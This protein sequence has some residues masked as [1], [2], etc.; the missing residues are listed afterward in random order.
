MPEGPRDLAT[1]LGAYR[2]ALLTTR[3]ADGHLRCRPMA[4]RQKVRGEEIWFAT[5]LASKKCKDLE[6]DPRCA[7]A[8]F[9]A[10]DGTTLSISGRGEVLRDRNLA[11][12][13]WDPSW[14]RWFPGGPAQRG[15]AL[16]R[17]IPDH[18][19]RHGP[20]GDVEVLREA[21]PARARRRSST[22]RAT[23]SR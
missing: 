3:G 4:M 19:E 12:A 2:I 11:L 10:R 15:L 13:L 20:T 9:D 5:A 22:R 18:V 8:L 17:V 14:T 6:A 7:L 21:P 23:A 1:L 16:L